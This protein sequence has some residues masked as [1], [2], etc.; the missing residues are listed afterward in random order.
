MPRPS[1]TSSPVAVACVVVYTALLLLVLPPLS[2]ATT[3]QFSL[4]LSLPLFTL[5][6]LLA[7]GPGTRRS[8][9]LLVCFSNVLVT[10]CGWEAWWE[11]KVGLSFGAGFGYAWAQGPGSGL[12]RSTHQRVLQV[13]RPH[14][15][16]ASPQGGVGPAIA[17]AVPVLPEQ[18]R[19]PASD[20]GSSLSR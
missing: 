9:L 20:T 12:C 2:S 1:P 7:T 3:L 13:T 17:R 4:I 5:A 11:A 8:Y 16:G 15:L 6:V 19:R 10:G 18:L 14:L